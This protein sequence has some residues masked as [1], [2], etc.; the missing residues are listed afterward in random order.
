MTDLFETRLS[1]TLSTL[2]RTTLVDGATVRATAVRTLTDLF[3]EAVGHGAGE[4]P[5]HFQE[6]MIALLPRTPPELRAEVSRRLAGCPE[7][8]LAVARLLCRDTIDAAVPI[9]RLSPVLAEADLLAAATG[10]CR[11]KARA[12]AGRV[13]LPPSVTAALI[14]RGDRRI[15]AELAENH[16]PLDSRSASRI[17]LRADLPRR[18]AELLV[19]TPGLSEAALASLFWRTGGSARRRI[20]DRLMARRPASLHDTRQAGRN[21]TIHDLGE[22][23]RELA[24]TRRNDALAAR[25]SAALEMDHALGQ[26]IVDDPGGE[27]LVIAGLA[28]GLSIE[29]ITGLV[30]L[31]SPDAAGSYAV[32]R[33]LV[34]FAE[35]VA[36]ESA[37]RMIGLWARDEPGAK[38][39]HTGTM[40]HE[41][42]IA[43]PGARQR[44]G[45]VSAPSEPARRIRDAAR[46]LG[47]S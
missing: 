11:H 10:A 20:V 26:R 43:P 23:L 42:A 3:L 29:Q 1:R 5:L 44:L 9:L 22:V 13:G 27:A 36:P 19:E 8:P 39:P 46:P 47:Q 24:A 21:Q 7:L 14:E 38:T 28:A 34:D 25:L 35:R 12:V 15:A 33:G 17:A 18:A 31:A 6:L 16:T 4:V 40:H 41:P 2:I 45:A 30:L 32:L 37:A